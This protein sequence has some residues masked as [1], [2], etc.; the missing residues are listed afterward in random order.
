MNGT[1]IKICGL[2]R[3][4]DIEYVNEVLPDFIGFVFAKS[5][6]QIGAETAAKLKNM[7]DARIKSAGVFVNEDIPFIVSLCSSGIVDYIQL[8]GDENNQYI[9]ALKKELRKADC[10][11][12]IIKAIRVKDADSLAVMQKLNSDFFLLDTYSD[13]GYGGTGKSFDWSLTHNISR[14]FFLAG[15]LNLENAAEAI[16]GARPFC[17]DVSSGVETEGYKDRN[18]IIKLV[19]L[20]RSV[21]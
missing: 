9:E 15:G 20:I 12:P 11:K 5:R 7:L 13:E 16:T 4:Q 6:R 21:K 3:K 19:E 2:T 8:H 1:R 14:P 18:K 10:Q 17:L